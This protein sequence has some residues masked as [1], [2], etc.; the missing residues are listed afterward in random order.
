MLL[1]QKFK[2]LHEINENKIILVTKSFYLQIVGTPNFDT[3]KL[4][5]KCSWEIWIVIKYNHKNSLVVTIFMSI[6]QTTH[7]QKENKEKKNTILNVVRHSIWFLRLQSILILKNPLIKISKKGYNGKVV[8][9][10]SKKTLK[11][12]RV[13]YIIVDSSGGHS[14]FLTPGVNWAFHFQE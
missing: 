9:A 5:V 7:I 12:K 4:V 11:V 1:L 2:I 13:K 14:F 8:A 6:N 10:Q 3:N